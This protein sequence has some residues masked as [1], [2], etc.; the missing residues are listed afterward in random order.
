ME[1]SGKS[2]RVGIIGIGG[3]Y[4]SWLRDFFERNGNEVIGSSVMG[5]DSDE[6]IRRITR[7]QNRQI[8]RQSDVVIFSVP[9]GKTVS[10]IDEVAEVSQEDQLF[11]DVTS[12]KIPAFKAMMRSKASV[13]GLHP[14]CAPPK[15]GQTLHGQVIVRC[16]GRLTTKWRPWVEAMLKATEAKMKISTPEEHDRCMAVVQGLTHAGALLMANVIRTM[17]IDV[18]E[19]N[20]YVSPPYKI[21]LA[22]I[23]RILSQDPMLYRDIQMENGIVRDMLKVLEQEVKNFRE[24][25]EAKDR[26]KFVFDFIA[27][28]EH[29]DGEVAKANEFFVDMLKFIANSRTKAV[30]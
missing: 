2:V 24:M 10:I 27:N 28:R 30:S 20:E 8:V 18:A 7:D 26:S 14:M 21:S 25:I 11:M 4:G 17:Q 5:I 3:S 22:V 12:I 13:V 29:F 23:G 15:L 19:I 16:D 9:I 6:R 1:T